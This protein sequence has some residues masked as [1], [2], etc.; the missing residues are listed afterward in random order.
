[1]GSGNQIMSWIHIEDAVKS[2]EFIISNESIKG[3]INISTIQPETNANF[4]RKLR[5]SLTV[6]F[7]LPTPAIGLKIASMLTDIEPSLLLNSVNFIPRKLL[8]AGF[9]FKYQKIEDAFK[10]LR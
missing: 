9:K 8:D 6:F 5:T 10:D 4:M 3:P 1:V 7:G 2:I